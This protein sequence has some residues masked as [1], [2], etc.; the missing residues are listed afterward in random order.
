MAY[1]NLLNSRN[2]K[3]ESSEILLSYLKER[4]RGILIGSSFLTLSSLIII[5]LIIKGLFLEYRKKNYIKDALIYDETILKTQEIKKEYKKIKNQNKKIISSIMAL[6]SNLNIMNE[7]KKIIPRDLFL[8]ELKILSNVAI[9]KGKVNNNLGVKIINAFIL[10]LKKSS[11]FIEETVILKEIKY[12]KTLNTFEF[13]INATFIENMSNINL[14]MMM[15]KNN[16]KKGLF[17][18]FLIMESYQL[19]DIKNNP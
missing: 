10:G 2:D 6:R 4:N 9:F 16:N 15:N 13:T 1:L 8:N 3:G 7:L 17:K 19:L 14:E 18:K 5:S 11:L 12:N